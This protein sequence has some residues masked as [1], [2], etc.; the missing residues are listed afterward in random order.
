MA[1]TRATVRQA[2]TV[3]EAIAETLDLGVQALRDELRETV[4]LV[5]RVL[6]QTRARVLKGDTHYPDKLLSLFEPQTEAIRKGKAAKPTEFGKVVKIQQAEAGL[7]TDYTVCPTRVPDQELWV[8]S[9]TRHQE[10]FGRPP[11]LAVAHGGLGSAAHE[12]TAPER[13]RVKRALAPPRRRPPAT[14]RPLPRA[15]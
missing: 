5:R 9:L 10:L 12:L 11:K 1:I 4:G 2:E 15:P 3:S 6:A 13:G 8:P 7:I 14:A